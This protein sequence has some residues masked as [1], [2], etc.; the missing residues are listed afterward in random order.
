MSHNRNDDPTAGM[1]EAEAA[2][3]YREH[4]DEVEAWN[5]GEPTPIEPMPRSKAREVTSVRFHQGELATIAAA[6]ERSGLK[7]G[8]YIRQAA[9]QA[10][11]NDAV[12]DRDVTAVNVQT[13]LNDIVGSIVGLANEIGLVAHI[14]TGAEILNAKAELMRRALIVQDEPFIP[15]APKRS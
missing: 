3:W 7:L 2:T 9:M 1:T 8:A 6:A 15:S 5:W 13:K 10:A 11:V 4:R 12:F 14:P